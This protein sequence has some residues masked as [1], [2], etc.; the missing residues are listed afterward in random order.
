MKKY[1][2][3]IVQDDSPDSPR[4]WDN[5]T[6]MFCFHKRYTLGD[7]HKYEFDNYDSWAELKEQIELDYKVKA[8]KPLYLFDHSGITISTSPFNCNW[9]SGQI[10]WIIVDE[11]NIDKICGK[12]D[13]S[14][15][16]YES[17]INGE[18][19]TYDNYLRGEVYGYKLYEIETCS[20]GHEHKQIVESCFGY[21]DE[22]DC[23]EQ[24]EDL[25]SH[26]EKQ[27]ETEVG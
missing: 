26:Y 25:L 12:D 15:D 20:L 13:Y 10:G 27:L 7:K 21:Y 8:I 11:D 18:V 22:A 23:K 2:I 4:E 1:Q 24:A 16:D 3:E 6:T 14:E 9:D 19:E 17:F 5:L